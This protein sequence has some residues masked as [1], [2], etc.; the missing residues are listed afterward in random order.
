MNRQA[1]IDSFLL[2]AHRLAVSRLRAQ[3]E[4][5]QE[6]QTQLSRWRTQSGVTRSDRYWDT[7]EQL[8]SSP[9]DVLESAICADTEEATVLRSVSP[10]STLIT[11]RERLTMLK[12]ARQQ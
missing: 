11:Q 3:P 2:G 5:M 8:L 10:F 7:W 12:Q 6:V 1:Q 9:I 4:R